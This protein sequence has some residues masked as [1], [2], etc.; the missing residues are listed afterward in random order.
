MIIF[1]CISTKK[2]STIKFKWKKF[3]SFDKFFKEIMIIKYLFD[4]N[5]I[6]Q[7]NLIFNYV[8]FFY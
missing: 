3:D 4:M 6:G 5:L 7:R 8:I 1:V 2:V